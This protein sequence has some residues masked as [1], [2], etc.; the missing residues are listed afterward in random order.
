MRG[1][2]DIRGLSQGQPLGVAR[3]RIREEGAVAEALEVILRSFWTWLGVFLIACAL[4]PTVRID[5]DQSGKK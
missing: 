1:E 3:Y 5:V 2:V 4:S